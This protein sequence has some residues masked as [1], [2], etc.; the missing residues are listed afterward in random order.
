M[1]KALCR[2]L[3]LS[4]A[5]CGCLGLSVA[6]GRGAQWA[7]LSRRPSGRFRIN[8]LKEV[9][10]KL[11][12]SEQVAQWAISYQFLKWGP[13][14]AHRLQHAPGD[15]DGSLLFRAKI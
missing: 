14:G 13:G 5:L 3:G 6:C 9:I 4:V 12:D 8:F 2:S 11:V 15:H 7:I 10:N 1:G